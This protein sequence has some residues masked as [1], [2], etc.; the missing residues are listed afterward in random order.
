M[1]IIQRIR[2]SL[3]DDSFD[4][5][6]FDT[7]N[8]RF[9]S[10][11]SLIHQY[12]EKNS[13]ETKELRILE[14]GSYHLHLLSIFNMVGY[15][16]LYGVDLPTI[17]E[18][19]VVRERARI[20]KIINKAYTLNNLGKPVKIP[21]K[22]GQFDV[23]ICLEMLEHITFN[24][25]H[26]WEEIFRIADDRCVL[27]IATPNAMSFS[28]WLSRIRKLLF[29][30]SYGISLHEIFNKITTGHHWKEYSPVEM[31]D[32]FSHLNHIF[33]FENMKSYRW[34][35]YKRFS[36]WIRILNVFQE[37][38]LPLQFRSELFYIYRADKSR[39]IRI[40]DP[41]ELFYRLKD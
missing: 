14:L 18:K 22:D 32:Y 13:D 23:I 29:R 39:Q 21:Y 4:R 30:R 15:K 28:K 19:H 31:K 25:V 6:Y 8:Q 34:R 37:T 2:A 27:I 40:A 20:R 38:I 7:H 17:V 41:D 33:Q 26:F 5:G 35:T 3:T 12:L 36:W 11:F 10:V 1:N 9:K 24:P 16:K